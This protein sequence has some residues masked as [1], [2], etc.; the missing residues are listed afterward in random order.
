MSVAKMLVPLGCALSFAI[1]AQGQSLPPPFIEYAAKFTCGAESPKE[2]DD[3]VSGVYASSINIHNPYAGLTVKFFKKIVVANREGAAPG[4]VLILDDS[5]F[6]RPDRAERVDCVLIHKRL[7]QPPTAY[8]EGFVVIEVRRL[9]DPP[10]QPLLDVVAKYTA[11]PLP[12]N[13]GVSTQSVVPIDGKVIT[14]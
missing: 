6:L 13:S 9:L 8:V 11:R 7:N 3:V 1:A 5:A 14:R 2:P 12:P 10:F 4:P